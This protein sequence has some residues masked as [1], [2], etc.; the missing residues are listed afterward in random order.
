MARLI[1]SAIM[2][3]DGFIEDAEGKFDW[4]VPD[5]AEHR[6]INDLMRLVGTHLYGRRM[7]ETMA[8]WETDL[9]LAHSSPVYAD[10]AQIWQAAD[11]VVY[12]RT[13]AAVSTARTQLERELNL[14]AVNKMKA[15]K[16]RDI[17]IAG[18]ELAANV[19]K[20]GLVDDYHFFLAPVV[21]GS[22]KPALPRDVGL[23]LELRDQRRFD[24]GMAY[25]R[26]VSVV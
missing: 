3:L 21:L 10:F 12:S 4:A 5:E 24:N 18:P 15:S 16:P 9:G 13:L 17:L 23:A 7:Y 2:S 14:D 1:F 26:Y 20:A 22:G 8:V 25:L 6:F 19:I 11:K